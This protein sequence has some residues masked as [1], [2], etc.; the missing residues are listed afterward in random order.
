MAKWRSEINERETYQT[1]R[2]RRSE[3]SVKREKQKSAHAEKCRS[4]QLANIRLVEAEMKEEAR[5]E[6]EKK[7]RSRKWQKHSENQ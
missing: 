4:N 1:K 6:A 7:K 3:I 5:E 2:E